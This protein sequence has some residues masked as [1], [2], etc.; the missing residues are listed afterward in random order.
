[1]KTI[2]TNL[3]DLNTDK[4]ETEAKPNSNSDNATITKSNIFHPSLK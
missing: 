3:K 2:R 4:P 1:M